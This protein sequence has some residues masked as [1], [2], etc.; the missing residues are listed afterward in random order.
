MNKRKLKKR[1]RSIVTDA[2]DIAN[3]EKATEVEID[4]KVNKLL[5]LYDTSISKVS[6]AKILPD[7]KSRRSYFKNLQ[8]DFNETMKDIFK[9][10][11]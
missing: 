2:I 11:K 1:I 4:N 5:D 6:E 3:S 8:K 9:A 7:T 10:E